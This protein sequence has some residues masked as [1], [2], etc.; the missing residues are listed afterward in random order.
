MLLLHASLSLPH[1]SDMLVFILAMVCHEVDS[2]SSGSITPSSHRLAIRSQV[3]VTYQHALYSLFRIAVTFH[4]IVH[5][6]I[7]TES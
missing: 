7:Q 6:A 3:V 5:T 4:F 1:S 2:F